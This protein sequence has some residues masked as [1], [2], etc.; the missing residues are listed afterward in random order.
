MNVETTRAAYIENAGRQKLSARLVL[1]KS[2]RI[3]S[4]LAW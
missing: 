1:P 4:T 2:S 3:T